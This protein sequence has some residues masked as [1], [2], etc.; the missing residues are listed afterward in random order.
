[1]QHWAL[2]DAGVVRAQNQDAYR[3]EKLDRNTFLCVVCDGMGGAKS[4]DVASALA[5]DTFIQTVKQ[6][7][8]G[9]MNQAE[10][11]T[12]LQSAL[13]FANRTVYNQAMQREEYAGM[14]TTLVALLLQGKQA[15][16]LNVGDSR[17]YLVN[18]AGIEQITRD[19]SFVQYMIDRGELTPEAAKNH[20]EK[21]VITRA[22][23]TDAY[24]QGDIFYHDVKPGDH[25]LLCTDGLTNLMDD[26]EILFEVAYEEKKEQCCQRLVDLAKKRGAPDNVT[27]VLV[28]V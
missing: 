21:N 7:R 23:G 4:G 19:H 6:S 24:V 28:S 10:L 26:R 15:T 5:A 2:T 17:G 18:E 25:F 20:P 12:I 11:A 13:D 16:L 1:M 14:G 8:T 9:N 27:C 3:V 22:V